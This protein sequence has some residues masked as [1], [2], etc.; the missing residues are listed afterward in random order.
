MLK[1]C[2]IK[3]V[4]KNVLDI[5][6]TIILLVIL[7]WILQKI[8]NLTG[9]FVPLSNRSIYQWLQTLIISFIL[10]GFAYNKIWNKQSFIKLKKKLIFFCCVVIVNLVVYQLL[11]VHKNSVAYYNDF[12]L[13]GSM[14][15]QGRM[16]ERDSVLGYRMRKNSESFFMYDFKN[17]I[18]VKS[19]NNGFR[20][21]FNA[22]T[23]KL[24]EQN[25]DLLFLGCSFT[26]GSGCYAEETFAYKTAV[27][28]KL[29]YGN[30]GVR[31]YGLAQIVLLAEYLIPKIKPRYVIL[32]R[33][34]WLVERSLF[35]FA[36]SRG[37]ILLPVPYFCKKGKEIYIE[38]PLFYNTPEPDFYA[39]RKKYKGRFFTY[40]F[41]RGIPYFLNAQLKLILARIEAFLNGKPRPS[42][43]RWA[44]EHYAYNR[45]KVI[46]DKFNCKVI[47]LQLNN[48]PISYGQNDKLKVEGLTYVNADSI[49]IKSLKSNSS[50]LYRQKF[51]HWKNNG[52]GPVFFDGHPNNYAHSLI[53]ESILKKLTW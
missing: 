18:P 52:S 53:A 27:A 13:P 8:A 42:S 7:L 40:Y 15:V 4:K 39:D 32:Q 38:K 17:P 10:L 49:L 6:V 37:G 43:D 11:S 19:D 35:E 41:S 26:F 12:V 33:S 50:L 24:S 23:S 21:P 45:I 29:S 2:K 25:I 9:W 31:G 46:A 34:P 28:N 51:G 3:A 36:P 16:H 20:I 44:A 30:G 1:N 22:E 14:T 47:I 5:V 48:G